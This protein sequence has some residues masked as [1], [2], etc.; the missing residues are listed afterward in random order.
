MLRF[1][2]LR[3]VAILSEKP[4]EELYT[5][6]MQKQRAIGD[7]GKVTKYTKVHQSVSG[8][9]GRGGAGVRSSF[10]KSGW[11]KRSVP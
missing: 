9:F 11:G 6:L 4:I 2:R 10:I 3:C 7:R 8:G 1:D 5:G